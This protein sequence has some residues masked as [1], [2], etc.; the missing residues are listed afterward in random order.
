[1]GTTVR[2]RRHGSVAPQ[3]GGAA[4]RPGPVTA[5]I[6]RR[7]PPAQGV[8]P[9]TVRRYGAV[10]AFDVRDHHTGQVHEGDYVGQS[11]V[12][13]LR[14]RQHRGLAPQRDGT[15]R[16]QPWADRIEGPMRIV[17]AGMFTDAELD[18]AEVAWMA[19]YRSRLNFRDNPNPVKIP[20]PVQQ[21]QRDQRDIAAGLTPRDWTRPTPRTV[22]PTGHILHRSTGS[23]RFWASPVGRWASRRLKAATPWTAVWTVLWLG[24]LVGAH[25]PATWDTCGVAAA[26]TALTYALWRKATRPRRRPTR[27]TNRR[28]SR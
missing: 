23:A 15:V 7:G 19:R 20:I 12:P 26:G 6:P 8:P 27:R 3:L 10:Y 17:Q 21:R 25:Q 4:R 2:G 18:A 22:D 16:E 14:D 9:S 1:M 28:R 24:L 13:E 5:T 11:R